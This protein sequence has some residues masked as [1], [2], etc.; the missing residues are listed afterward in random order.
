MTKNQI[1]RFYDFLIQNNCYNEY[2]IALVKAKDT[3]FEQ[4]TN[5]HYSAPAALS[6]PFSWANTNEVF[7]FWIKLSRLWHDECELTK[8]A[9]SICKSIW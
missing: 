1:K 7:N 9:H 2:C 5:N 6:S 3:T 4:F 8:K